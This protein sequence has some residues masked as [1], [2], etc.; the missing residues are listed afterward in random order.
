MPPT[1]RLCDRHGHSHRHAKTCRHTDPLPAFTLNPG[2]F[3][4]SVDGIPSL[5]FS[6]NIAGY[7]QSDYDTFL[8]WTKIG[9]SKL[10]RIHLDSLVGSLGLG[11]TRTGQWMNPGQNNGTD[12]RQGS[13]R[14]PLYSPG[15]FGL[16]R[17]ECRRRL[18]YLGIECSERSKWW[19]CQSTW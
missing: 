11:Y 16:V 6:R 18:L 9:G 10:V 8:D 1:Q 17:L 5:F 15:V 14:W 3:Y 19:T 13:R 2:D 12:I 7:Q 4:F